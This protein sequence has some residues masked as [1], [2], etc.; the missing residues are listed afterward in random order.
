MFRKINISHILIL[1]SGILLI[2][3]LVF[4]IKTQQEKK[5][6][7]EVIEYEKKQLALEYADW[8]FQNE[9]SKLS[10]GND[11]LLTL[12]EKER[13]K[14]QYLLEK[15][16]VLES[17]DV[18]QFNELR[19]ELDATREVARYYLLQVDS[20]NTLNKNLQ[21]ENTQIKK[22]NKE[23]EGK[24]QILSETTSSLSEK[25]EQA[26]I[27][28][29]ENIMFDG[30]TTNGKI[31]HSLF[32]TDKFQ[33]CF[34][35]VRNR[36]TNVGQKDVYLRFT[37]PSDSLLVD[38]EYVEATFTYEDKGIPFTTKK[39]I[40]YEGEDLESCIYWRA[41]QPIEAGFYRIELFIDGFL[42]GERQVVL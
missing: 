35:I 7:A 11:S 14:M 9:T 3:F 36:L 28:E 40:D 25:I 18:R 34:R 22:R 12:L 42:V 32:R 5:A 13:E 37:T 15:I 19:K 21:T 16:K 6:I 41:V 23:V 31:T 4:F 30:I 24:L 33:C 8:D 10:I 26:S 38:E 1:F 17:R 20:L 2:L 29:V 27:L 39:T